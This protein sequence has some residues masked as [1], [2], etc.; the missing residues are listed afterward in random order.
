MRLLPH[1][2]IVPIVLLL[3]H[4]TPEEK[5]EQTMLDTND[6]N[7]LKEEVADHKITVYQVFTRLFGNGK[8]HNVPYGTLEENGVGKFNDINEAALEEIRKLG[9][10]HVW[11]TGVIEHATMTEFPGIPSD[12]AD[13]VKGRAG[14]PYAIK[15]YYDVAPALAENVPNRMAEFE[16]LLKRTH[17][18]ELK[19]LVDFV[20][21]HV[22]RQYH[23]DA[24][25]AGVKDLGEDDDKTKSFA[26]NNNF[27][28]LPGTSFVVPREYQPL[29]NLPHPTKDGKFDETPAK[30]TG[31]DQFT[32]APGINEWFETVKLNYG[33]DIQNNRTNHFDPVPDTWNKMRDILL[34]WTGK[35][36]D[37]FRC[38]MAEMVPVEFWGW[39]IPQVQAANKDIVFIA[40]IYNPNAY[41]TYIDIG[42][43]DYL[44]DKVGL[45]DTV[46]AVMQ[47]HGEANF[48]TH[49]WKQTQGI[50]SRLLR[51]LENHDEQ[52]IASKFFAGDARRGIPGMTVTA[53][54]NSGPVM[55]YFGQEVGEPALGKEGFSGDDGRTTIFDYWGVP[56]FQ[57]WVNFGFYNGVPMTPPM[58]ELRDFYARLLKTCR[59]TEAIRKGGLYD[60]QA[61]NVQTRTAGYDGRHIYSYLRFSGDSRV[62]VVVNFDPQHGKEANIRIPANAFA[63]MGL[64]TEG[65]YRLRNLLEDRS[66]TIDFDAAQVI[67]A[68]NATSGIPVSLPPLGAYVF[69][70]Q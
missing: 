17:D 28:Y 56:V 59:D 42:K 61:F 63:A 2:W 70:L 68:G 64:R 1:A 45:Y 11:Y 23:S 19:V 57:L 55:V 29:E 50:N 20:P 16:A 26:A 38:D 13:V 39:V 58:K 7:L 4:C 12:D 65:T 3:V 6:E 24:K 62:L 27:Y 46:R 44:Y 40:E 31:N 60:L 37:G 10:T 66:R 9:I 34:F 25:P 52:R 69:A 36:V 41:R 51:F 5:K 14:S 49:N 67:D 18:K 43:F 53:T 8:S 33:V 32:N 47:G 54:L 48:I 30:V 22:A 15:D 21:N 35:G